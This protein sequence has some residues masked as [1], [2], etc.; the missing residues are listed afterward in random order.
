M[1]VIVFIFNLCL[2]LSLLLQLEWGGWMMCVNVFALER[3]DPNKC[4]NLFVCVS[5]VVC[6]K[7][8][9]FSGILSFIIMS[10]VGG[11]DVSFAYALIQK[12]KYFYLIL[13]IDVCNGTALRSAH[14][15]CDEVILV[16]TSVAPFHTHKRKIT[17]AQKVLRAFETNK[18]IKNEN[19]NKK[20]NSDGSETRALTNGHWTMDIVVTIGLVRTAI[21]STETILYEFY[22]VI[23]I[24]LRTFLYI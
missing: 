18:Q 9:I 3:C 15:F 6:D 20:M 12:S 7:N 5:C 19:E 24:E 1:C 17:K 21:R 10:S 4:L 8:T 22:V 11:N 16:V 2:S 14:L 13:T 23:A